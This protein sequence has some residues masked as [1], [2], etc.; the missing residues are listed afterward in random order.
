MKNLAP[1]GR[2]YSLNLGEEGLTQSKMVGLNLFGGWLEGWMAGWINGLMDKRKGG[3][4]M[5]G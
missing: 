4:W 2:M 3:V 5:D 1:I